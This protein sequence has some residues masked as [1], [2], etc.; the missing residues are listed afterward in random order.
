MSRNELTVIPFIDFAQVNAAHKQELVEA[1]AEVIDS[2]RYILGEK[3]AE[4]EKQFAAYCGTRNAIGVGNGLD[5]LTLILRAYIELG[6][7]HP[8]DEILVPSNTYIATILSV[9]HSGLVPVLV[10]PDIRT[11][12]IDPKL[13]EARITPRTK[14]V[15]PVHLYGQ[16]AYSA[17][18]QAIADRHGLKVVE[19]AAQAHGAVHGGRRAGS[20]GDAS[21]FSLYPSKPLGAAGGDAGVVTTNDDQLA[22]AIRALR[23][24]GSLEKYH[25]V[26]QGVNSR[27][28]EIHA[29][30]LLIKLRYLDETNSIRRRIAGQYRSGIANERILLPSVGDEQSHVW[31]LFVT[32]T[33][34]RDA[35]MQHL[36]NRGVGSLIHYPIA[37]HKQP[38]LKGLATDSHPISEAIHATVLSLPLHHLLGDDEVDAVIAAC[39]SFAG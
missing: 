20:L 13:V 11:F 27:L 38:A 25:N 39:N 9:I 10:E 30:M 5:A 7:M 18:L 14:A 37:P 4:F 34:E 32:R 6:A 23:N 16:V 24:Y 36:A 15:V 31:H 19:D 33:H 2:G 17:E 22:I 12:N 1:V 35:F 29:A 8:G 26:Y 21:G 28:D 3:V